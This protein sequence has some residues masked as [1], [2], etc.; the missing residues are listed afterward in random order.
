MLTQEQLAIRDSGI[1]GSE[2]ASALGLSR[3]VT[4]YQLW[5]Y[6]TKLDERP[7]IGEFEHIKWGHI[8]EPVLLR[9]FS[10]RNKACLDS[11]SITH[12]HR[13]HK[14]MFANVDALIDGK[15]EGVEAK[16]V[17]LRAVKHWGEQGTDDIPDEYLIQTQHYMSVLDYE[18]WHVVALIGGNEYR[19]YTVERND[20]LIAQ[21]EDG[22]CEFWD[23]VQSKTPPAFESAADVLLAH[24][25][26]ESPVRQATAEEIEI[27]NRIVEMREKKRQLETEIEHDIAHLKM[28][29]GDRDGIVDGIKS[30]CMW[31]NQTRTTIDLSR[32]REELPEVAQRY[33][34]T[35]TTRVFR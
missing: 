6:K 34:K 9:E 12:V 22:I 4:R 18:R 23:L 35:S 26:S 19:Q 20:K 13:K 30:L 21:I 29:I 17:G 25:L 7:D 8:I 5:R 3:Y 10:V 11:S 14:H 2:S 1:G 15:R 27:F 31:R 16:N 32:L 24:P 28:C 33:S